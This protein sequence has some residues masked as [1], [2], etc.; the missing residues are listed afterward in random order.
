MKGNVRKSDLYYEQNEWHCV[1]LIIMKPRQKVDTF[2]NPHVET[3]NTV[4]VYLSN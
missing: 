3:G 4:A 2:E 1:F